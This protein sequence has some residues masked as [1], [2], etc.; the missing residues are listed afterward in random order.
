MQPQVLITE[1]YDDT[2]NP[3]EI[4]IY[5][6]CS[7]DAHG[8]VSNYSEQIAFTYDYLNKETLAD[9]VSTP[10]APIFYPNIMIP[11]KTI[12]FDNDDK[13]STITPTASDKKKFTL[14]FTPDCLTHNLESSNNYEN[15]FKDS[16]ELSI[17]RLNNRS[18]YEDKFNV[19][20]NT[21]E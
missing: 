9:L 14:I 21:Q 7:I 11:R 12:F 6:I 3:T 4:T 19:E 5:A 15:L 13:I 17:F 1:F 16:Y 10:G 8:L 2:F 18:I 20:Y